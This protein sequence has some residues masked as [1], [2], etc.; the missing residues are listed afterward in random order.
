MTSPPRSLWVN[1][2]WEALNLTSCMK[3]RISQLIDIT[4][5]QIVGTT[6]ALEWGK[7]Y[8]TVFSNASD[9]QRLKTRV[10]ASR[11]NNV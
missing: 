2:A 5:Q 6:N 10:M 9:L 7:Q 4:A 11:P 3:M 1:A 8:P